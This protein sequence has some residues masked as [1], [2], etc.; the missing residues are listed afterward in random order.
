[1]RRILLL[2]SAAALLSVPMNSLQAQDEVERLLAA[3]P[4]EVRV[5]Q[6]FMVSFFGEGLNEASRDFMRQMTPGGVGVFA[7]NGVSPAAVTRSTNAWQTLAT[8]I[9]AGVPL[10]IATDQEG[11]TVQRLNDGFTPFPWGAASAPCPLSRRR[12]WRS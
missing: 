4:L 11:G 12:K 8:Q 1:M 6:L 5:G 3:M 9:G 7:S 2:L 10:L